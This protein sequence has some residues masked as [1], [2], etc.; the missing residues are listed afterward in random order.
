MKKLI[1]AALAGTVAALAVAGGA[2][3]APKQSTSLTIYS[4]RDRVLVEPVLNRFTQQ[5]G[6]QLNVRYASSTAL[7]TARRKAARRS[8]DPTVRLFD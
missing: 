5:T 2:A 8:A 4:G 3:P 7:A 1:A 6:I